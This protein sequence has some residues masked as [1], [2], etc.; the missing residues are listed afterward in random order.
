M[1]KK[2]SN[3]LLNAES[4]VADFLDVL[5]QEATDKAAAERP[6]AEKAKVLLM[7]DIE[8]TP[9]PKPSP[10]PP[11]PPEVKPAA[12]A[13]EAV[14]ESLHSAAVTDVEVQADTEEAKPWG[15]QV[16][17]FPLQ[18]LMFS[19]GDNQLSI[20]LIDLGSVLPW[21]HKLTQLPNAPDW[22]LGILQH[23]DANVK[24]VDMAKILQIPFLPI[25][26]GNRHLLVF[27]DENW[28][29]SC[30]K[31][32]QVLHLQQEDVQWS[33]GKSGSLAL[34]T[35]RDSLA[36]LLDPKKILQR[37]NAQQS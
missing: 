28:A 1:S 17:Q 16:Y 14:A 36:I 2:S 12:P 19:V 31:L 6:V 32:G 18:C 20:P 4:A 33:A 7:P 15:A 34:G 9:P 5:L 23:R 27:G 24:V 25:D 22:F 26:S 13:A 21:K 3:N 11:A 10:E 37:L 30:D 8:L 35:I 29:I